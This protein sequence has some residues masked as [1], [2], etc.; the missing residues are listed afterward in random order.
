MHK[1]LKGVII[2]APNK[3]DNYKRFG[4]VCLYV[5]V[6]VYVCLSLTFFQSGLDLESC[7]MI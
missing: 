2:I 1:T 4:S 7:S 5:C 6:C 3:V